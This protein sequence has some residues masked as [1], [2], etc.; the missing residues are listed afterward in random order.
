MQVTLDDFGTGF[1]S[2]SYLHR[3]PFDCIKID[4]SFINTLCDD[5]GSR[6]I[7]QTILA[8]GRSLRLKVVAEGVE[9]QAQLQWLRSARCDE[10]QGFLLGRPMPRE[11]V[12]AFL[13]KSGTFAR[14][15]EWT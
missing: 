12:R 1:S 8:L 11:E 7:V 6:A 5:E 3:F 15:V 4:R 2:L 9:D 14:R 10:I 13:A